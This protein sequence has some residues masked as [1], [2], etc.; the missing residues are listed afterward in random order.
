VSRA[1]LSAVIAASFLL[2]GRCA[3]QSQPVTFHVAFKL[4]DDDNNPIAGAPLRILVGVSDWDD[5][6]WRGRDTGVRIVT[7]KNGEAK[8]TAQGVVDRRWAWEPVGFTP[9]S[10]PVRVVHAG[11]GFEAKRTLPT[12]H[13]DVV[14]RWFYTAEIERLSSG[15]CS[16]D[17]I[18]R[19]YE[20]GADGRFTHLL[21]RAVSS[22]ES[23]I[24]VDGLALRGAGYGLADFTL[25]PV[26]DGTKDWTLKLMLKQHPKPVLR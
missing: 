1:V 24:M 11:V 4:V 22:P 8:F 17:D 2:L 3:L 10:M 5:D 23:V 13:G 9:L 14:R 15:D 7:D 18:D 20:A 26:G 12:R 16:T 21:G 6:A 25:E 19:L